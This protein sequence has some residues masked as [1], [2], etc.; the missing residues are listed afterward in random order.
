VKES[1]LTPAPYRRGRAEEIVWRKFIRLHLNSLVACDFFTKSV[2][3]PLG[4]RLAHCLV[5]IHVGT[6]KVFLSPPTYEPSPH[7]AR[8]KYFRPRPRRRSSRWRPAGSLERSNPPVGLAGGNQ[9]SKSSPWVFWRARQ[10][11][12]TAVPSRS[13][14]GQGRAPKHIVARKIM[15]LPGR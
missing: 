13:V 12:G 10:A 3:T 5:F 15:A 4:A 2:I 7:D 1:G 14:G 11:V 6:R 8:N 9:Y